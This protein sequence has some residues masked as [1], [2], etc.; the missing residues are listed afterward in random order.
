MKVKLHRT[1]ETVTDKGTDQ[2][3][4]AVNHTRHA[5]AI[6]MLLLAAVLG[7]SLAA[8]PAQAVTVRPGAGWGQVDVLLDS[9]ETEQARRSFWAASVICWNSGVGGRVLSIG[10]CQA[11]VSTCAAPT[12]PVSDPSRARE[13]VSIRQYRPHG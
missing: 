11:A 5:L 1:A 8:T 12:M 2:A 3:A 9:Y 6:M 13:S 4:S 10:V 7:S